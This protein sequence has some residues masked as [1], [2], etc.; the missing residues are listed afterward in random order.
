MGPGYTA[1][2]MRGPRD[3]GHKRVCYALVNR[4]SPT[5]RLPA[6]CPPPVLPPPK[7]IVKQAFYDCCLSLMIPPPCG[8]KYLFC[9]PYRYRIL[10]PSVNLFA[11]L[12]RSLNLE[13][14]LTPPFITDINL[15]TFYD[16]NGEI[17]VEIETGL[18]LDRSSIARWRFCNNVD[19]SKM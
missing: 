14:L 5:R 4:E 12:L 19:R 1:I 6:L 2:G 16:I 3:H 9:Q 13:A 10:S 17:G 15:F 11:P 8:R 18:G 7:T